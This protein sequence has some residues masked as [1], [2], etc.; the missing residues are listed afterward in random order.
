[1][2]FEHPLTQIARARRVFGKIL[3]PLSERKHR[4]YEHEIP[5][6]ARGLKLR[7]EQLLET[8]D[9]QASAETAF[10]ALYRL[11]RGEPGRPKYP[12]FNWEFVGY[13]LQASPDLR[14]LTN[15]SSGYHIRRK[16]QQVDAYVPANHEN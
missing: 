6:V 4:L 12:E 14:L 5:E 13:F 1:M 10:C 7:L 16:L 3:V 15:S 11:V 9:D 2:K 8:Q